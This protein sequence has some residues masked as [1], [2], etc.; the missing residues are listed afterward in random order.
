MTRREQYTAA[1]RECVERIRA[2]EVY[3]TNVCLALRGE[4]DG[5]VV[6]LFADLCAALE[7]ARAAL[8][9]TGTTA[10]V[11][12]S[13][14]L[15]LARRG[16]R[17]VS[18][19]IKGTRARTPGAG[20]DD[21]RAAELRA[22]EKERAE[23]VMIVDL[24]RHDLG[25]VAA[26]GTVRV[27][28]LLAVEPHVGVWHLLSRVTAELADG[29]DDAALL[30]AT[31]PP[32]SVTGAPKVAARALIDELED[33]PRGVY[34]GAVGFTSP[35]AGLE[36]SVAIR[37]LEVTRRPDGPDEVVL[38]VGAGITAGSVPEREWE[39]CLAKA[40]PLLAAAGAGVHAPDRVAPGPAP[41]ARLAHRSPGSPVATPP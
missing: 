17:V 41:A 37:T 22:D 26:T 8:V 35:A 19:P 3:Q 2:G 25:R 21:P 18:A 6:A 29:V 10:V 38:G 1:V 27:P 34:T 5:S 7:P 40:A 20:A 23:N 24:V 28:T 15:F 36:L 13:P 14:E 11:S 12:A 9:V 39:E 31:F 30:D 32:G 16:R 33:D 4:L